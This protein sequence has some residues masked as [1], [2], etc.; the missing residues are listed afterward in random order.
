MLGRFCRHEFCWLCRRPYNGENGIR[1]YGNAAHF[2]LVATTQQIYLN[3]DIDAAHAAYDVA[4]AFGL[5][6]VMETVILLM[7]SAAC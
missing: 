1:I 2:R 7:L 6:L 3:N 5:E 4:N